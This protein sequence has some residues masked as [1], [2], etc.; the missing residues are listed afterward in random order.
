MLVI[1]NKCTICS[2]F[3]K[4]PSFVSNLYGFIKENWRSKDLCVQAKQV[5][6]RKYSI[7]QYVRIFMIFLF[8]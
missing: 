6:L 2:L 5:G 8:V 4:V 3:T 7:I 1:L